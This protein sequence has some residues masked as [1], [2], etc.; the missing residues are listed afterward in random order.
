MKRIHGAGIKISL[1]N[2][3]SPQVSIPKLLALP[4]DYLKLDPQLLQSIEHSARHRKL[5]RGI[6]KLA[7][8]LSISVIQKGIETKRQH[9]I[10]LKLGCHYA[11]G[12]YY[13]KPI[14]LSALNHFIKHGFIDC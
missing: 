12:F 7:E 4:L 14:Q 13:C 6:I 11:Q 1:D 5:L 9:Q 8:E 3:G 10:I 2:F